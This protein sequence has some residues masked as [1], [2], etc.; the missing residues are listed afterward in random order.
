MFTKSIPTAAAIWIVTKH[1]PAVAERR[2]ERVF[3]FPN[4]DGC[5]LDEFLKRKRV[6]EQKLD[7]VRQ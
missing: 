2:G 7:E 5:V 3:E 1:E 4:E 6:L